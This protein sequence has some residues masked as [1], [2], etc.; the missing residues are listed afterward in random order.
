M[1]RSYAFVPLAVAG[2]AIALSSTIDASA[3]DHAHGKDAPAQSHKVRTPDRRSKRRAARGD[4]LSPHSGLS[5]GAPAP[6]GAG[7]S[8][9]APAPLGAGLSSGAPAPLGAGLS[10]GAPAP[11][12]AT[13]T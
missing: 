2:L 12:G 9:G 10:S 4:T 5:S 11:L 8:S 1:R 13:T 3:R 6:L 7:L